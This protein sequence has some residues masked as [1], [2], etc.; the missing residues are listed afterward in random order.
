[1]ESFEKLL[2][3][4]RIY[5]E[6]GFNDVLVGANELAEAV[7]LTLEF[8]QFQEKNYVKGR[9]CFHM[10]QKINHYMISKKHTEF[11]ASA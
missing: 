3:W 8:R 7:E 10:R 1:M 11:S 4:L 6:E 9:E 2:P 5:R